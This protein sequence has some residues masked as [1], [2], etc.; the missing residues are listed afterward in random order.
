MKAFH[1][2]CPDIR[3]HVPGRISAEDAARQERTAREILN[4]LSSWPG[5]ILADEVG[6]GK[7]FV[8]LAVAVSV[9]LQNRGKRPVVVMIP[10]SLREKWPTD[11]ALFRE[12]CLPERL[13]GRIRSAQAD[14]AA[15]F[16]KQLDEPPDRRNAVIF[17][18]HGAMSR[19]LSDPWIMLALIWQ[20]LYRRKNTHDLRRALSSTSAHFR[21]FK[22]REQGH[23]AARSGRAGRVFQ[24]P[25]GA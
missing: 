3:L 6:M 13:A 16:L 18:T 2:Y 20:S 7:T 11:F 1:T 19:G 15:D 14:R 10:S 24:R 12:R 8:A 21:G 4:R 23:G 9:A 5:V 25:P 22:Q 17:L